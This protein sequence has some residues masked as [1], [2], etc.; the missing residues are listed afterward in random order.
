MSGM[1]VT[2]VSFSP[3]NSNKEVFAYSSAR[4]RQLA[5]NAESVEK[6]VINADSYTMFAKGVTF[7]R[8]N[9][10]PKGYKENTGIK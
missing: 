8:V 4:C 5:F 2:D 1:I 9:W 10:Y 6:T 3:T 7:N